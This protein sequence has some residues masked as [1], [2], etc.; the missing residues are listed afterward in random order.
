[1]LQIESLAYRETQHINY[2]TINLR[3]KNATN[4]TPRYTYKWMHHK[5][6]IKKMV[7]IKWLHHKFMIKKMVPIKLL[8]L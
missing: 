6:M 7:P 8:H 5:F 4:K 1:M 3:L 2:C